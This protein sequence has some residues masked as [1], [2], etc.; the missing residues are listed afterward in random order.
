MSAGYMLPAVSRAAGQLGHN[1]CH[2]CLLMVARLA[3][4]VQGVPGACRHLSL[5]STVRAAHPRQ[6]AAPTH[7]DVEDEAEAGVQ[8]QSLKRGIPQVVPLQNGKGGSGRGEGQERAPVQSMESRLAG[9]RACAVA[10]SSRRWHSMQLHA[11]KQGPMI[12]LQLLAMPAKGQLQHVYIPVAEPPGAVRVEHG[13][14]RPPWGQLVGQIIQVRT[15]DCRPLQQVVHRV[16]QAALKALA[17]LR[18][19]RRRRQWAAGLRC[20]GD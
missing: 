18:G 9:A 4:P 12:H 13:L 17:L 8:V 5:F 19:L 1:T 16:L 20:G 7:P 11:L 10:G 2:R 3:C 14:Q 15:A 6:P